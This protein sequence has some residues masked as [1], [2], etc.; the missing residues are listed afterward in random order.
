[1]TSPRRKLREF[2]ITRT[3]DNRQLG[4]SVMLESLNLGE[5]VVFREV[6]PDYDKAVE[7]MAEALRIY[8]SEHDYKCHNEDIKPE[9]QKV[10][11]GCGSI[12]R[13]ALEAYEKARGK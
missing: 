12:A 9:Y 6:S 13:E 7:K 4:C 8:S 11:C 1:M 5:S 10:P 3:S 2:P